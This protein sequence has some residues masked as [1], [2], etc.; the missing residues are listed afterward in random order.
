LPPVS[1]DAT[2][3]LGQHLSGVGVYSHEVLYGLAAAHPEARFQWCYRPHRFLSSFRESLPGNCRRRLLQEP[4][5]PSGLFHGLN[6]RLPRVR[7]RHAVTT[8]HDLF[9]LTGDYSTP[10]FRRRFGEQARLAAAESARII[11]VSAFTARQVEQLLGVERERLRVIHHGVRLAPAEPRQREEIVL[12]VGA[13]QRRKNVERLVEAFETLEPDW[14][15]VLVGSAGYGSER[16]FRRIEES[17]RREN[18]HVTGWVAPDEL[19]A[20]YARASILAFPSFDEGFGIPVLEAMAAGVPVV[21][22]NGS[23]LPEVAGEAALLIDPARSE[24]LAEA[25]RRLASDAELR[26]RLV[27]RGRLRAAQFTW[28]EAVQKTWSVYNEIR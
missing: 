4:F 24:Q 26:A 3:S 28:G 18:I 17:R 14:R 13:I 23:A 25:L 27:R 2:Y 6:Q 22:S 9:V 5:R 21:T 11:C 16:I 8:F 20:W 19:A 10:E 15:L 7:F 12:H 1:L